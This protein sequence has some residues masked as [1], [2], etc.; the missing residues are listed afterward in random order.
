M[1]KNRV[2]KEFRSG[3]WTSATRHCKL[4]LMPSSWTVDMDS[5]NILNSTK[6]LVCFHLLLLFSDVSLPGWQGRDYT[7]VFIYFF[8]TSAIQVA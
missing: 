3:F 4:E 2:S 1:L 7:D 8:M 5:F 6:V